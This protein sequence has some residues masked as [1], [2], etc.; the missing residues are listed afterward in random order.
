MADK[1][2]LDKAAKPLIE[3]LKKYGNPHT[4]IIIEIDRVRVT[5]DLIGLPV[6]D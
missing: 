4:S 2:M 5:E 6:K 3:W 1:E